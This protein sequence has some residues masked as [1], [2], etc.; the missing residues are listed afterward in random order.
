LFCFCNFR[1]QQYHII[2][3]CGSRQNVFAET[4]FFLYTIRTSKLPPDDQLGRLH[5]ALK[6]KEEAMEQ[7]MRELSSE[8]EELQR[9]IEQL[10]AQHQEELQTQGSLLTT[11]DS[12]ISE[13]QKEVDGLQ[14]SISLS[15]PTR[16]SSRIHTTICILRTTNQPKV[17]DGL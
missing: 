8:K 14:A 17:S 10:A 9:A 13:L 6:V 16:A 4:N 7:A 11:K 2:A 15:F 1:Q 12:T 5:E 3:N